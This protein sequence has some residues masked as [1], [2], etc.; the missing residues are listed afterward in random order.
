MTANTTLGLADAGGKNPEDPVALYAQNLRAELNQW[1]RR[2]GG[3]GDVLVAVLYRHG[4]EVFVRM[5]FTAGPG[6]ARYAP[7]DAEWNHCKRWL[8]TLGPDFG[9]KYY[10]ARVVVSGD[11]GVLVRERLPDPTEA[12]DDAKIVIDALIAGLPDEG[13]SKGALH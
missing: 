4:K 7:E 9:T 2:L 8:M 1:K 11:L 13:K 6:G 5:L 3:A 10:E 12:A